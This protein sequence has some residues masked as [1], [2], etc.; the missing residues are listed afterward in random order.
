MS[1]LVYRDTAACVYQCTK[2]LQYEEISVWG[3]CCLLRQVSI[4][5]TE[6]NPLLVRLGF[7]GH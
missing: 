4:I 7:R 5:Q 6:E 1:V 2:T 3:V